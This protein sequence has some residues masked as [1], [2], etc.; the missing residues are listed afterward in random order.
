[1]TGQTCA[2][3]GAPATAQR[4]NGYDV[5]RRRTLWTWYCAPHA[6]EVDREW[7]EF[8]EEKGR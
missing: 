3:C 5:I 8:E 7:N 6:A 4:R 2:D 1:M